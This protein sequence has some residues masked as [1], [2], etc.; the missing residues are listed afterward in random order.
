M[1]A[2]AKLNLTLEV[3]NR[4]EDGYHNLRSVMVP[5]S[6]FDEIVIG[7]AGPDQPGPDNLV[8]K[9]LRILELRGELPPIQLRKS[10]PTGAGLGGG[11]SDA[12]AILLSAME[13]V[14]GNVEPKDYLALARSLGSDVPFFLTGTAAIVEGTGERVTAL[15]E[16]P[17][18]N[19]TVIKPP[20][21]ISTAMAYAALDGRPAGSRPRNASA[22]LRMGEALQ[23][24]EFQQVTALL[25]ND[26]QT[27]I[28]GQ[29]PQV[30]HGL[31]ALRDWSGAPAIL[32]GSGSCVF[33]LW[34]DTPPSGT[35]DLPPDYQRYDVQFAPGEQWRGQ[36]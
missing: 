1:R 16:V 21:H 30:A 8:M 14:F 36:S 23:R 2:P 35:L 18:W 13:G 4:R 31:R 9:A 25:S 33:T 15:G 20:V 19:A 24:A 17:S 32:T 7:R 3:L 29:Y 22:T 10:I 5:I 11:S 26:F 28:A 6:I 12:A 34:Q 27:V